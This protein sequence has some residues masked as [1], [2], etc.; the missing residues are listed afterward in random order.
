MVNESIRLVR[1]R[2]TVT[3]GQVGITL[4]RIVF[5]ALYSSPL[6]LIHYAVFIID[7][8]DDAGSVRINNSTEA[9][10]VDF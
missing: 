3:A 5:N 7:V 2:L 4:W 6:N 9:Y 1:L 8:V 10:T